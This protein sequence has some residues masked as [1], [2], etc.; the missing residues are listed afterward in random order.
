MKNL[1]YNK[2]MVNHLWAIGGAVSEVESIPGQCET[3]RVGLKVVPPIRGKDYAL[4]RSLVESV[5]VA[6]L[7]PR[8]IE[9]AASVIT[10]AFMDYPLPGQYIKDVNRRRIALQEMFKL[11]LRKALRKGS[12]YTLGG[13]F[14]E[15][16]IWKHEVVAESDFTYI[17][18]I[19]LS[20][21]K[22][23]FSMRIS[24]CVRLFKAL[25]NVLDTKLSL[26]LPANAVELYI[27]GVNPANQ[28]QGRL[29]R[30][31]KPVL[32]ALQE[33]GRPALVMTNTD[34]N[35]KIYEH[36]GFKLV[37]VLN[38]TENDCISYYLVK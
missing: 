15:V 23:L 5:K 34:S 29:S 2:S 30:L 25:R 32:K 11:E 33:Q 35:R 9:K 12:V 17:K 26:N 13:D 6:S 21:L 4:D 38:D 24:E 19:R 36:L 3:K 22:L 10:E 16:A 20:T 8:D 27:V 28:G 31:L 14:Q 7:D 1:D 37:K 18:Y